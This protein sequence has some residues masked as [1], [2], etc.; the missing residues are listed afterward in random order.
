MNKKFRI[1]F[2]IV[3]VRE[4][5]DGSFE[6]T[7]E[8][9]PDRYE[10]RTLDGKRGWLDKYTNDFF[11]EDIM[12]DVVRKAE[13][14]PINHEPARITDSDQYVKER[15]PAIREHLV[16]GV[17]L[18]PFKDATDELLASRAG[19]QADFVVCSVDLV[20]STLLSQRLQPREYTRIIQ[21]YSNEMATAATMFRGLPLKF[22]GD[23]VLLYFPAPSFISK[24]DLA[25]DCALTL[26]AIVLKGMNPA[27]ESI[28]WPMVGIR[29]GIDAGE[30]VIQTIG[31]VGITKHID[32]IGETINLAAKIEKQAGTNQI[33][34]GATT[35][36]NTHVMWRRH[37]V[38][39]MVNKWDYVDRAT[40]MPYK[41]YCLD[42]EI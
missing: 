27:L 20:G 41:I 6:I 15:S 14:F 36:D 42:I 16:S 34:V 13:R 18:G 23:G 1:D 30:A 39:A 11:G 21:T 28:G 26:R 24:N 31:G 4:N 9:D 37:M 3:A 35:A 7:S 10:Q 38:E 17:N 25:I 2:K 40:G 29:I 8:P 32:L 19:D 5:A 22:M 33:F 12:L